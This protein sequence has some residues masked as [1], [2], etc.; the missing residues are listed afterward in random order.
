MHCL[1]LQYSKSLHHIIKTYGQRNISG[2]YD[3]L[4]TELAKLIL[5]KE[6]KVVLEF[7][8][9]DAYLLRRVR[10]LNNEI[11]LIGCD[12]SR[13]QIKNAKVLL[14][15]AELDCQNIKATTYADNECDVAVGVSVLMYLN[16]EELHCALIEIKRISQIAIIVEYDC[17]YFND[18]QKILFHSGNDG[19][20]DYNFENECLKV[21]FTNVVSNRCEQFWDTD[22][23]VL[24]ELGLSITIAE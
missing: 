18:D 9:G 1:S 4:Y 19:R 17:R 24:G 11:K 7:G 13:S 16:P 8:C 20:F 12:F 23:N 3:S 21:G 10:D 15:D 22:I 14:K 2:C 6:P 5:S